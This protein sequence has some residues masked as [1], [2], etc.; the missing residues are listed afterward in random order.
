MILELVVALGVMLLALWPAL[1]AGFYPEGI[2]DE[3]TGE[4]R[5]SE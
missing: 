1:A 2:V 3:Q 4:I 5:R